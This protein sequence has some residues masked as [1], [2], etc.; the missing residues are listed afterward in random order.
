[1]DLPGIVM[2]GDTRS[3]TREAIA[4][5]GL[6]LLI[7]PFLCEELIQ[8]IN[9]LNRS[10]EPSPHIGSLGFVSVIDDRPRV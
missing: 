5:H 4:S 10:L 3:Q 7:K 2:T 9:R 8:L 1:L 6:S